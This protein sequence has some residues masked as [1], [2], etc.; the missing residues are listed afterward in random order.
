MVLHSV[1]RSLLGRVALFAISLVVSIGIFEAGAA[2]YFKVSEPDH[3]NYVDVYRH[4]LEEAQKHKFQYWSPVSVPFFGYVSSGPQAN[5]MGFHSSIEYP[6]TRR[7][8]EF[9]IGLFGGSVAEQFFNTLNDSRFKAQMREAMP[10]IGS[11]P[12]V[13]LNFALGGFKQPQ[14][15]IASAYFAE[16]YDLSINLDGFNDVFFVA[17]GQQAEKP[18]W[19]DILYSSNEDEAG[20]KR[21]LAKLRGDDAQLTEQVI[22][23]KWMSRSA[24][25][26]LVW[27]AISKRRQEEIFKLN[28]QV[29]QMANRPLFATDIKTEPFEAGVR[30]WEKYVRL[31]AAISKGRQAIFLLQPN[32]YVAGSKPI[33][34]EEKKLWQNLPDVQE[35]QAILTRTYS[36]LRQSIQKL[37]GEGIRAMDLSNAFVHHPEPL[38]KDD[39]CHINSRGNEVIGQRLLTILREQ[40]KNSRS[41]PLARSN[42]QHSKW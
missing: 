32:Q 42:P 20:I 21:Q 13:V 22:R 4:S 36:L 6:Y 16:S 2:L 40:S 3:L 9:V 27:K 1:N 33:A 5:K 25:I 12:L 7:G 38:Y 39:C 8:N 19:A 37:Q 18:C 35:R 41:F 17:K 31:Q 24:G 14:Q 11:R 30:N 29:F 34:V 10:R 15:F 28:Q 23:S 26:Y